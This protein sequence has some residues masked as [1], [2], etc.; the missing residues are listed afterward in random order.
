MKIDGVPDPKDD[1]TF[2]HLVCGLARVDVRTAR[3]FLAGETVGRGG[4][5]RETL[6][7][8]LTG[9]TLEAVELRRHGVLWTKEMLRE[10]RMLMGKDVTPRVDTTRSRKGG[11]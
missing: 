6:M 11:A 7:E 5:E 9:A 3:R 2:P 10:Y 8:R 1:V 4:V